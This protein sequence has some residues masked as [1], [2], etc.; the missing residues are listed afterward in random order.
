MTSATGMYLPPAL[1]VGPMYG[2]TYLSLWVS[3]IVYAVS[4]LVVA[5]PFL[6]FLLLYGTIVS[7]LASWCKNIASNKSTILKTMHCTH[8]PQSVP[9][10]TEDQVK[11]NLSH[12][13]AGCKEFVNAVQFSETIFETQL[14][15]V[16]AILLVCIIATFYRSIG[17][18]FQPVDIYNVAV[19]VETS[20][21][22]LGIAQAVLLFLITGIY[23]L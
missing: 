16:C 13:F 3:N 12:F 15:V 10:Q 9:D 21:A 22:I 5:S 8:F 6:T 11:K 4:I 18:F 20:Y 2:G 1:K 17:Y 23:R 7:F 14:F 19:Y